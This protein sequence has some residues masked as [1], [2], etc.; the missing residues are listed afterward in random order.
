MSDAKLSRVVEAIEA[1]FARHP[2]AADSAEGIASWWLAGA[3]IEA[4]AD[5]VRNALAILAERGTVVARRMP[6]GRLIYVRGPRRRD[7][8]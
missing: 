1:Y 3:G 8:H 4:R 5:E 6:D 2:D 7:M